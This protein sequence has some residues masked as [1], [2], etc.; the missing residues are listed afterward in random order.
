MSKHLRSRT[1]PLLIALLF[2]AAFSVATAQVDERARTLIEGL[3]GGIT[4]EIDSLQM[5]AEITSYPPGEGPITMTMQTVVDYVGRRAVITQSSDLMEGFNSTFLITDDGITM[6][7]MGMKIPAPAEL[8]GE[9]SSI[10]DQP[11]TVEPFG[12]GAT[13]T[14]DGPVNYG[15]LLVGDQVTYNGNFAVGEASEGDEVQYVFNAAGELLGAHFASDDGDMLMV[16]AEPISGE[17]MLAADMSM[18]M[19][20]G[21]TWELFAVMSYTDVII[22]GSIDSSLFD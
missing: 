8:T 16:Y 19:K 5:N 10:F 17:S 4:E 14:F 12:E 20:D 21:D 7:M 15:D 9:F 22:N 13:A 1:T 3:A 18:Y 11:S 6:S 2:T